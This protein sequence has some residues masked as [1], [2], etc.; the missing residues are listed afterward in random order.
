MATNYQTVI[1]STTTAWITYICK[2]EIGRATSSPLWRIIAIDT[3]WNV[4]YPDW[5]NGLPT[6]NFE[7]IADNRAS[8]T[9]SYN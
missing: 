4:K 3:V 1:D 8:L 2:A 9:Y 6:D 7:F 5:E